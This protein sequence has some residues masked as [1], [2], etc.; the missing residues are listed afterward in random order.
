MSLSKGPEIVNTRGG[1]MGKQTN[2][3]LPANL[4]YNG[5]GISK[6]QIPVLFQLSA[7]GRPSRQHLPESLKT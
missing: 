5:I 1:Q 2:S 3:A 6:L 7:N 4:H